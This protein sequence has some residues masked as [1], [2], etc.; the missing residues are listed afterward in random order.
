MKRRDF[1]RTRG[2]AVAQI[3]KNPQGQLKPWC[4]RTLCV[5]W[6]ILEAWDFQ[7]LCLRE[8]KDW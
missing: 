4:A 8:A 1:P 5:S 6:N 3:K 2:C 7:A